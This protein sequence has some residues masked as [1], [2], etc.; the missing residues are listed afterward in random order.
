MKSLLTREQFRTAVFKRDRMMCAVP[1]CGR[2]MS[3]ESAA[4]HDAHHIYERKLWDARDE[5]GGYFLENGVTVCDQPHH[6]YAERNIIP[7]QAFHRWLHLQDPPLPRKLLEAN[8]RC[9]HPNERHWDSYEPSLGVVGCKYCGDCT[10]P[11]DYNKWGEAFKMPTREG[12]DLKYPS[13]LYLPFSPGH[14]DGHDDTMQ[15]IS[16]LVDVPLV[17]TVKMDGSNVKLVGG[18]DG[19]VA[20]RAGHESSASHPSFDYL[21]ARFKQN[22]QWAAPQGLVVF[23]EWLFAR[24]SIGYEGNLAL[25]S[26]LQVFGVYDP[27]YRLFLGWD[28]V[29]ATAELIGVPT[30]PVVARPHYKT[31]WELQGG[32]EKLARQ[33]VAQGH[34]G[35]VVRSAYPFHFGQFQTWLAK[36]VREN[37]VQTDDHW[38]AGPVVKNKV[39]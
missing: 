6:M 29:E 5:L 37:H 33:V 28:E 30:T 2:K 4:T 15:D 10:Q 14:K 13:S 27:A 11:N 12:T 17:V 21:K 16:H 23:G 34:E 7:P 22:W 39:V 19:Y 9:G 1:G 24:H 35:I 32:L 31:L 38:S 20:S 25:K 26:Y 18:Q 36:Y 8:C 3:S